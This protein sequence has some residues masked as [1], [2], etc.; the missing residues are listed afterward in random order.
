MHAFEGCAFTKLMQECLQS[1]LKDTHKRPLSKYKTLQ[2][3]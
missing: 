1:D 2:V 3:S